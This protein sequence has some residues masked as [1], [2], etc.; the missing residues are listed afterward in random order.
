M[1][2]CFAW[3]SASRGSSQPTAKFHGTHGQ[4]FPI[5]TARQPLKHLRDVIERRGQHGQQGLAF[6]GQHQ[7]T[8]QAFEQGDV[9]LRFEAFDL[10]AHRRL[11]HA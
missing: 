2:G 1:S 6:T 8:G 11:G 4:H 3:K 10:M 7:P 9:E 5:L